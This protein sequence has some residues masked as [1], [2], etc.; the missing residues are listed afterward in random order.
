MKTAKTSKTIWANKRKTKLK[1][2]HPPPTEEVSNASAD[3]VIADRDRC[4][5][6]SC[7]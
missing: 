6:T 2:K 7:R 4:S 3:V 5:P 1:A